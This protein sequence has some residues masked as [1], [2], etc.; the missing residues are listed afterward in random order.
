MCG[1][2]FHVNLVYTKFEIANVK[3]QAGKNVIKIVIGSG[4]LVNF[5]YI[6]LFSDVALSATAF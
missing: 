6:S 2:F 4:A 5:D 1:W 3:L